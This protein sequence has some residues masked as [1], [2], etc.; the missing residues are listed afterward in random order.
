[1]FNTRTISEVCAG[2]ISGCKEVCRTF[3]DIISINVCLRYRERIGASYVIIYLSDTSAC[4]KQCIDSVINTLVCVVKVGRTFRECIG[5]MVTDVRSLTSYITNNTTTC[6]DCTSEC[7]CSSYCESAA[8]SCST[9]D[10]KCSTNSGISS[11]IQ[12]CTCSYI[13][14]YT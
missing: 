1:M 10:S 12:V 2:P 4:N 7:R 11:Y 6:G 13:T 9:C 5:I 14:S 8:K 3:G